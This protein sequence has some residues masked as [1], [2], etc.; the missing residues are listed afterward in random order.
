MSIQSIL[1]STRTPKNSKRSD[2]VH[3]G[4]QLTSNPKN[5]VHRHNPQTAPVGLGF[6]FD[7]SPLKKSFPTWS[8]LFQSP[9]SAAEP[10]V[11]AGKAAVIGGF[12]DLFS[13]PFHEHQLRVAL[14]PT[15]SK[16]FLIKIQKLP[17]CVVGLLAFRCHGVDMAT[18][19]LSRIIRLAGQCPAVLFSC[20]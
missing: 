2:S 18:N 5:G 15:A 16:V 17:R 4:W 19:C 12:V 7:T 9:G 13:G 14:C 6:K 3:I 8:F 20:A 11:D 1:L 10:Y